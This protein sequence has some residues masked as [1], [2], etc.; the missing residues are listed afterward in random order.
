MVPV[1]VREPT[2]AVAKVPFEGLDGGDEQAGA[3][4]VR[5]RERLQ[6]RGPGRGQ[7]PHRRGQGMG[8]F[9]NR[10]VVVTDVEVTSA[11]TAFQRNDAAPS[12]RAA[13]S[14]GTREVETPP[15]TARPVVVTL[16]P[17]ASV[18]EMPRKEEEP[19]TVRV[20]VTVEEA[21]TKPPKS[22]RVEV[23]EEPRAETEARSAERST[24][25]PPTKSWPVETD[26]AE[27]WPPTEGSRSRPRSR[28]PSR[29]GRSGR[30]GWSS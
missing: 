1:A 14:V 20:E 2:R 15:R 7:V 28:R 21:P 18:K 30:T 24:A 6:A 22:W 26:P 12:E 23:A 4:R 29:T 13:S 25:W 3:G 11:R 27:S 10:L 8:E 19:S 16:E 9:A 17:W 5:E